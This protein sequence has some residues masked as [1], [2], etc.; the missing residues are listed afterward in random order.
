MKPPPFSLEPIESGADAPPPVADEGLG[1]GLPP[2][3]LAAR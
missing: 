2:K 1:L 3:A